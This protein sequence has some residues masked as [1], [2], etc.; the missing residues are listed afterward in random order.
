MRQSVLGVETRLH[1]KRTSVPA[2]SSGSAFGG[3]R[4]QR[5]L[6]RHDSRHPPRRAVRH[7]TNSLPWSDVG[8]PLFGSPQPD[9]SG[10]GAA[11]LPSYAP[12]L[13]P[14]TQPVTLK[15]VP[16][17]RS[18]ADEAVAEL[19]R[20][21]YNQMVKVAVLLVDERGLA[22]EVVQDAFMKLHQAW[23]HLEDPHR[24]VGYLRTSV[25]NL[26][27]SRLRRRMV[28]RKHAPRLVVVPD[29]TDPDAAAVIRR[30]TLRSALDRLPRRQREVIVLRYFSELSEAETGQAL[31]ISKGAVKAYSSRGMAALSEILGAD[32]A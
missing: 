2:G 4:S 32:R 17:G 1:H 9:R 26:S 13:H 31:G 18:G 21:Y 11:R 7:R 12:L 20:D 3:A 25:V 23:D 24:A 19:F 27:R 5:N 10:Q 6:E 30:A 28:A 29:N 8:G 14:T 16:G 22:E 15:S